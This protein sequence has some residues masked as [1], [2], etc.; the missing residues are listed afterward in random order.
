MKD[1][2]KLNVRQEHFC[3]LYATDKEYF[4]N[5][6]QSYLIAYEPDQRKPNW[7]D[8]CAAAASRLLRS[9][10]VIERIN[11]ILAETGFNDAHI[12]KQLSFLISQH[13]DFQSKLGAIREYNKLKKR[14]DDRANINVVLPEPIYGGKSTKI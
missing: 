6:V 12:D 5:G 9:V 10:K 14:I 7:Y 4:G 11:A 8:V 3:K 1:A 2:D 13:A